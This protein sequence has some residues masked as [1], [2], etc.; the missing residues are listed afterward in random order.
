MNRWASI[1]TEGVL[2]FYDTEPTLEALQAVVDGD[3]E[4]IAAPNGLE[5]VVMVNE[6]RVAKS[7]GE[8]LRLNARGSAWLVTVLTPGVNIVGP[9]VVTGPPDDEGETL[10]LPASAAAKLME[11]FA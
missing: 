3:L 2:T 4:R 7:T 5:A 10:D 6:E 8:R 9:I 1:S 11:R